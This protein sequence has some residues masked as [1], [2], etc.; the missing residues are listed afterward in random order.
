MRG[1]LRT[2]KIAGSVKLIF[3]LLAD[4]FGRGE[5]GST[6]V[7]TAEWISRRG[8]ADSSRADYLARARRW[9]EESIAE[10]PAP[11]DDFSEAEADQAERAARCPAPRASDESAAGEGITRSESVH[12]ENS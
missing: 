1:R 7:H 5:H 4:Y 8:T 3:K 9:F 10:T 2:I 11:C 12:G 6:D